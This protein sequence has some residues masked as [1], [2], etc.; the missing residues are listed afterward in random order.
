MVFALAIF[1]PSVLSAQWEPDYRL[2]NDGEYSYTSLSNAWCVAAYGDTVHVVWYDNRDGN[3]EIY[4]NRSIDGGVTWGSDTRLTNDVNASISPSLAVSGSDIHV[5]WED[6]RDQ[7]PEVYHKCSTDGGDTWGSDVRVST[8]TGSQGAPSVTA[9]GGYIHVAWIDYGLI[10]GTEIYYVRSTDGGATWGTPVQIS[11][12]ALYSVSPSIAARESDV[13][14]VWEDSRF[15]WWNNEIYYQHSTDDGI[16]WGGEVRLTDDTTFSFTPGIAVSGNILHVAWADMRDGN[17][18]MYYKCSTNNGQTWGSDIRLT[19]NFADSFNPSVA[20]SGSYVHMTWQD[21]REG[22]DEIYYLR[23]TD[24]GTTWEAETRLTDGIEA[25]VNASITIAGPRVHVVWQ[26][27]RDGNAEIY[28]KR[29]PTGNTGI[30]EFTN[31]A[32]S[33]LHLAATPNP[34][35]KLTTVNFGIG[36]SAERIALYIYDASGRLVREFRPTL[37]ALRA[38]QVRWDGTDQANRQLGSGVYF[39]KLDAGNQSTTEKLLLIR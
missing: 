19:D 9:V 29:N 17:F 15:G 6:D 10:G 23:S 33:N 26:D 8:I 3:E 28:Y 39:V 36:Q 5:V 20:A 2:T 25:S 38:T 18:E 34:F 22:N 32:A 11:N 24:N 16:T 30:A 31:N 37:D 13:H 35:S 12:A 4:Y 7:E 21:N 1:I 27:E 14:I